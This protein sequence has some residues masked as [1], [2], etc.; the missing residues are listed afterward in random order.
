MTSFDTLVTNVRVVRHEWTQPRQVDIA[1]RD[2][3][4]VRVAAGIDPALARTV[5]DGGGRLAFPGVVDAHQHWGIYNP[6]DQ[7]AASESRAC[8]QGGVTSAITYM[9]TGQYYLNRGG[10]YADFFPEVLAATAERSHVDYAFHLAPMS[11]QHIGEIP[12]LVERHGVT[13][14]KVFM[15]YGSHGLHGRSSD[16]SS[17]LMIPENE[18]YD[19][20]HFEFVMRGVQAARER[21]P[22]L[23]DEI[24]LSLHCETAEIMNAYTRMVEEEGT[25][26]GLAAYHA[27]RPPH[28][29]GLAVSIASYLAHET[30]LPTINLLHLTS[31][32]A[33]D[34][35]LRM[36]QA[37]P[38]IDFR[39]EVTVGHLLADI[40]TANLGAKVNPPIRPR[41]DVEALWEYV[42]DGK[43]DWVVSDHACCRDEVKFGEP[44]DDV[45]V[46]KSG[47]GGAEYLLPGLVSEGRR[48]GLPYHRIAEM[49]AWNPAR[50]FGLRTKGDI[51][52]GFDA[53]FCLVDDDHT[54]TVRAAD[55][56]SVQEYTPFEGFELNAR[57]TDTFLRGERILEAGA[58]VG[59][60][61]GR[62]LARPA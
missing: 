48:R 60:P 52:E 28:S 24:S 7:D 49:T 45:F 19:Y 12:D 31:R 35:A 55:S 30:G 61:R 50:R 54:W 58:V 18:R 57:V 10:A 40:D 32:K 11:K 27:S 56:E 2:G 26:S 41:E 1:I 59:T 38:H 62:Y 53:D 29:E 15:F 16:Q 23:A 44:R 13:S 25:L 37:F 22:E 34:A 33:V 20:A 8:A 43:I 21:F 9:R 4:V 17:F 47:F 42:L 5:V 14:F 6:L 46:A 3:R 36:S 51:A 39:R